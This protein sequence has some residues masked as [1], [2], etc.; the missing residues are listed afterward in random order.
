MPNKL[1]GI[2]IN[3]IYHSLH[4]LIQLFSMAVDFLTNFF[5]GIFFAILPIRKELDEIR[6][7]IAD[8]FIDEFVDLHV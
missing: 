6:D 1:I 5:Q 3:F 2:S 4:S 7:A 8:Q